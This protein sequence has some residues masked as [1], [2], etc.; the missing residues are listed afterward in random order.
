M[1]RHTAVSGKTFDLC[2]HQGKRSDDPVHGPFFQRI[3]TGKRGLE[4]L[5]CQ[6][7]GE[8]TGG[9]STVAHIQRFFWSLQS[10]QTFSMDQ[11]SVFFFFDIN[12]HCL[13]SPDRGK[14]VGTFQKI[15]HFGGSRCQGPQH[16]GTVGNGFV[17]GNGDL[18][19]EG[20]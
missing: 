11:Q 5:A 7:P 8:K 1:K 17:T 4:I 16:D 18:S 19:P 13:K 2:S 12:P 9:G 3:I 15:G 20:S 10:V 14:T 6:D